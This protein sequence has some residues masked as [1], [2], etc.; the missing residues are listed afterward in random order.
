MSVGVVGRRLCGC[1]VSSA[2]GGRRE[3]G[4]DLAVNCSVGVQEELHEG[5]VASVGR[6]V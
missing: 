1:G 2:V 3:R 5:E 6:K 4:W